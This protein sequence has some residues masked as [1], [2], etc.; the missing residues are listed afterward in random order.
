[1]RST[2]KTT[3]IYLSVIFL[4]FTASAQTSQAKSLYTIIDRYSTIRAYKISGEQIEEQID[5][6]N[7]D[8]H[9]GGAVGLALDPDS[10]TMFVT[11]EGPNI[12]EMFNAKTMVSEENPI[13]VPGASNL[14]GIAFDQSK[15]KLY[16]IIGTVTYFC[17]LN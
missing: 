3:L 15:Q 11:Y 9:D 6:K 5:V 14:A 17:L 13:M 12:I 10:A 2:R 8:D 16:A 4:A 1:M 7:L